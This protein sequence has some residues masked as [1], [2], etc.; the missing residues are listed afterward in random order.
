MPS[1]IRVMAHP[2]H[3]KNHAFV[4]ASQAG[5]KWQVPTLQLILTSARLLLFASGSAKQ[6]IKVFC[7]FYFQLTLKVLAIVCV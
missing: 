7:I 6:L 3:T 2:A 1:S 5:E 4:S